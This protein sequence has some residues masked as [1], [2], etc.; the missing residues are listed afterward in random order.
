MFLNDKQ[1]KELSINGSMIDPFVP[2]TR[3]ERIVPNVGTIKCLSYGLSHFGYDIRL[4]KEFMQPKLNQVLDPKG[5]VEYYR[6]SCESGFYEL[7][8][9]SWILGKSV[10]Y[11]RMPNNVN[12]ICLG[13]S[14]YARM[15]VFV[16]VT[17]L[18][19]GWE[20]Y[21]TMEIANLGV[22]TVRIYCHEGIAQL[23]F[24]KGE[25]PLV[26]YSDKD[27]KYQYQRGV[28]EGIV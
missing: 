10:E 11:F 20:G 23:L 19:P 13:K 8:P 7:A 9:N 15:G 5:N 24:A 25:R 12:A 26:S 16:N 28:Q 22:H 6:F 17:P 2:S 3:R 4:D 18:E 27:G 14:T 1:I 21:L